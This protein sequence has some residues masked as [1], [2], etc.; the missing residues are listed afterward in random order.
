MSSQ[1]H[2]T[3]RT[4]PLKCI[5]LCCSQVKIHNFF[6]ELH[7]QWHMNS[8]FK[9]VTKNTQL[10]E[11]LVLPARTV[12]WDHRCHVL[13]WWSTSINNISAM[14][15]HPPSISI[16]H[17]KPLASFTL[18]T[19]DSR[20][21]S[22][23]LWSHPPDSRSV[24]SH[25]L[26]G[27]GSDGTTSC[28]EL[29]EIL[30]TVVMNHHVE[31]CNCRTYVENSFP[32]FR[33]VE[34]SS[35]PPSLTF[36][37][38]SLRFW[39]SPTYELLRWIYGCSFRH[40]GKR[41]R[42]RVAAEATRSSRWNKGPSPKRWSLK[43]STLQW[44][45]NNHPNA[46]GWSA[47]V[48]NVPWNKF[49]ILIHSVDPSL[50]FPLLDLGVCRSMPFTNW[51]I[52]GANW[53]G[54]P[55]EHYTRSH[56]AGPKRDQSRKGMVGELDKDE[57]RISAWKFGPMKCIFQPVVVVCEKNLTTTPLF[58]LLCFGYRL[59]L[60]SRYTYYRAFPKCPYFFLYKCFHYLFLLLILLS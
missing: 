35:C 25:R 22:L 28:K 49:Q 5:R 8:Q 2:P 53:T 40:S 60:P 1:M 52:Q 19:L 57:Q 16:Q 33:T 18:P 15:N 3:S 30:S 31:S 39:N 48:T 11:T 46:G 45:E 10:A 7:V 27:E 56:G 55:W 37:F 26:R 43:L 4:A 9:W 59:L 20:S 38:A 12:N 21:F 6:A 34:S 23:P 29:Q 47:G 42:R 41:P 58:V 32:Q 51:R 13:S 44:L 36:K 24:G 50:V 54:K 14:N 17:F